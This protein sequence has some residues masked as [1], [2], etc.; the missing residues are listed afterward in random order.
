MHRIYNESESFQTRK[1]FSRKYAYKEKEWPWRV[2]RVFFPKC[3]ICTR[4]Q[5]F[6][7]NPPFRLLKKLIYIG[8]KTLSSS[9][10][11]KYL[12]SFLVHITISFSHIT[13][14]LFQYW[15]N[16]SCII[17]LFYSQLLLCRS[18]VFEPPFG[19]YSHS[20][21]QDIMSFNTSRIVSLLKF[22]Q[23]SRL[24][25]FLHT[26]LHHLWKEPWSKMSIREQRTLCVYTLSHYADKKVQIMPIIA[27]SV[28]RCCATLLTCLSGTDIFLRAALSWSL[29]RQLVL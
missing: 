22:L 8:T 15:K 18:L 23:W 14:T 2:K 26:T 16:N 6:L 12:F 24:A 13:T 5:D 20:S 19:V 1:C 4:L 17:S 3:A 7:I 9:A 25:T 21:L 10:V 27:L 11:R 29:P 28:L